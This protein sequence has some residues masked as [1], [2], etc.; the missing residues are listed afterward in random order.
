MLHKH[1]NDKTKKKTLIGLMVFTN[2]L[3]SLKGQRKLSQCS[4]KVIYLKIDNEQLNT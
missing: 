4:R 3:E 1:L 2:L